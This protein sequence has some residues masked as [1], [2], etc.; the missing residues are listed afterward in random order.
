VARLG[1]DEFVILMP[2]TDVHA[3]LLLAERLRAVCSRGA[4]A[5]AAP[6]TVSVGLVTF[7]HTPRSSEELLTAADALMYEAKA[8]GGDCVRHARV[9]AGSSAADGRLLPFTH[10][11]GRS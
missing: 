6:I 10:H 2:E 3:A 5:D 8:A 11:S 9:G 1:G 4:G 7:A